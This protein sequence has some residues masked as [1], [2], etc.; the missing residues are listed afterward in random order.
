VTCTPVDTAAP[1]TE[2][3]R[4]WRGFWT[5][6]RVRLALFAAIVIGWLIALG[7]PSSGWFDFTTFY[8]AGGLA[9]TSDVLDL[10]AISR[11]QLAHGIAE[12]PWVYPA[13]V[14][15]FYVP[16]A[17]LPFDAAGLLHFLLMFGLLLVAALMW[18]PLSPLPRRW[19]LV[20]ALAWGPAALG[21]YGGQ[22]TSLA[23]LL[24]VL[25]AVALVRER[26]VLAGTASGL[27]A[28]KPQFAA[29]MVG[30]L[31]LRG[32]WRAVFVVVV[33]AGLHWL[34]G[35]VATGGQ[36]DWP[37]TWL[38]NVEAYQEA[39]FLVNGWK[40]ISLPSLGRQLEILTGLPGLM[41][42]GYAIGGAIVIVCL[43]ALRRLPAAEAVALAAACGLVVS[44][45]AWAY[46]AALLLPAVAVFAERAASRGWRWQD[47]WWLALAYLIGVAWPLTMPLDFTLI[48]LVVVATPFALLERGPFRVATG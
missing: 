47:R 46:D 20:G 26:E 23:L 10:E 8:A 5:P 38:R 39:D 25:T 17:A 21:V 41:I 24:V 36:L 30:L 3:V 40:S 45:H 19:L 16:F 13:G 35:V 22:N 11:F 29:P 43:P 44:P 7:A 27:L 42:A 31:L 34:L 9:F 14:A 6:K 37:L 15:L 4:G 32:R 18:A 33:V 12:G 1:P 48:P 2:Q 28:Y